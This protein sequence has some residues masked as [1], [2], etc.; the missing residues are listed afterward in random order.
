MIESAAEPLTLAALAR[1]ARMSPSHL[2]RTF[3]SVTG[4]TPAQYAASHRAECARATLA[5]APTVTAA[6]YAAGFATSSRFY[7][8]AQGILGMPPSTYRTGAAGERIHF[9]IRSS[10]LGNVLIAATQTG[11]CAVFL[12]DDPAALTDDLARRFPKAA[13]KKAG[14][15]FETLAARVVAAVENPSGADAGLPLDLRG[16]AFQYRVWQA[17]RAVPAG[18]TISYGALAQKLGAPRAV[19]AVAGACGANPVAILVP[20]HRVIGA[21]GKPTGYRWGIA[22]KKAL[23]EKEKS[24]APAEGVK[25]PAKAVAGKRKPRSA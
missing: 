19:R 12:G 21:D 8:A 6:A 18:S 13:I 14:A 11:I 15:D 23:L 16:T 1:A 9:A 20:C 7:A 5:S 25:A 22:R 17:L 10:S 2:H 4:L 3:R 24:P